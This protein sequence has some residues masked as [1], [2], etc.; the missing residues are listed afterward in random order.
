MKKR[1]VRDAEQ[2]SNANPVISRNASVMDLP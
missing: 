2:A 1:A